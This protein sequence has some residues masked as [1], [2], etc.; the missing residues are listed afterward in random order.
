MQT[1]LIFYKT[2]KSL[3][4]ENTMS[5][6][7]QEKGRSACTRPGQEEP[8]LHANFT[9]TN[10]IDEI[11]RDFCPG[12]TKHGISKINQLHHL[13]HAFLFYRS[14]AV[15]HDPLVQYSEDFQLAIKGLQ[16]LVQKQ[17]LTPETIDPHFENARNHLF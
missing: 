1:D 8:A 2:L 14:Q 13:I 6:Q 4:M 9:W 3:T 12:L 7:V 16:F 5:I 10:T 17:H 11:I 15:F